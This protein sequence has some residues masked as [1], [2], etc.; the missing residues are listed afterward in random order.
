MIQPF[1]NAVSPRT[2]VPQDQLYV[3]ALINPEAPALVGEVSLSHLIA[4]CA[5]FRYMPG[6]WNFALSEDMPIVEGQ[7]FTAGARSTAPGA[8]RSSTAVMA[9]TI[10]DG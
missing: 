7:V 6:W 8:N 3:W 10:D 9:S 5:T 1:A 4:D 2:Y